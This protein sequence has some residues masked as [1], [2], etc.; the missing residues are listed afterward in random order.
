MQRLARLLVSQHGGFALV[1]DSDPSQVAGL[2]PRLCHC[3]RYHFLRP[4]P[5]F[6]G[7]VLYPSRSRI[8][9]PVFFLRTDHN[10]AGGIEHNKPCA[11]C[12]L[13]DGAD[14]LGHESLKIPER[15]FAGFNL[16]ILPFLAILVI[17]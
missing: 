2:Q 6:F 16:S 10:F 12:A 1:R 5:D 9:L 4:L 11:R 15:I 13:I 17:A 7:I 3:L 8:N 14:V